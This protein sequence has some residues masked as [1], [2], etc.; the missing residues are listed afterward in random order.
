[1][2]TAWMRDRL[3]LDLQSRQWIDQMHVPVRLIRRQL[4]LLHAQ[5]SAPEVRGASQ[6]HGLAIDDKSG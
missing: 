1:M 3:Y 6:V 5:C 2:Y 4:P